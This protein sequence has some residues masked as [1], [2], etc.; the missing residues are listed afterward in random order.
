MVQA[1]P[2]VR[3][4]TLRDR[5][6]GSLAG[7]G[8]K[9]RYC[10]AIGLNYRRKNDG[11]PRPDQILSRRWTHAL[12]GLKGIIEMRINK[13][14]F[15]K[16]AKDRIKRVYSSLDIDLTELT[17]K[18]S[19]E[20][21]CIKARALLSRADQ[22]LKDGDIEGSW[23]CLHAAERETV[24][25]LNADELKLRATLLEK[26]SS[27]MIGW[28][29]EAMREMLKA[30]PITH[31]RVLLAMALRDDYDGNQYHKIWLTADQLGLLAWI[32]LPL[33]S[34]LLPLI[35]HAHMQGVGTAHDDP[36][37]WGWSMV[38]A[39]AYLG[40]LGSTFSA[41]QSLMSLTTDSSRIPQR[42]A[43]HWITL[44]RCLLGSVAGIAGYAFYY[45]GLVNIHIGDDADT[46]AVSLTVA[47]I[48]GY[49]G[50]KL[51]A[52]VAETL[53]GSPKGKNQ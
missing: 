27:K 13:Y 33:S 17:K 46:I 35:I 34:L 37:R 8:P 42:V 6:K 44:L 50:E 39:V 10:P 43:N 24:Y 47:F 3:D 25:S 40:I 11:Y 29:V 1:P 38:M 19:S 52:R 4:I 32:S 20:S 49:A 9:A 41:A 12:Y 7:S 2:A 45:S 36:V 22:F 5:H 23:H 14:I 48:F 16:R 53:S 51:I 31:E 15:G 30:Q 26:E 21:W 18:Y 28:R